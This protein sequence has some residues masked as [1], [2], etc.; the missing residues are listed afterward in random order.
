MKRDNNIL[1][2]VINY[3]YC[4]GCGVCTQIKGS[5]YVIQ[6]N[7]YGQYCAIKNNNIE[8]EEI[9]LDILCVC[10]F[11]GVSLNED[12]ISNLKF[13]TI[14]NHDFH[15]G[16]YINTYAGY[17]IEHNVRDIGA[18]G[19]LTT[20]LLIYLF[21]NKLIDGVIHVRST[22]EEGKLFK[23][24]ISTS[25]EQIKEGAKS[26]YYPIELSEVLHDI[27]NIEG[28]YAIVGVPCFIKAVRL[29]SIQDEAID[30]KIKYYI[31]LV[32]GHLKSDFFAKMFAW[33]ND[34]SPNSL[35]KI[36]FRTK[37]EGLSSNN[38]GV[39]V[40]SEQTEKIS[41]P[42][43]ELYGSNWGYG[44]FKYKACDYCDD[45]LAETADIVFG[46]AWLSRYH[47]DSKGNNIVIVRN[48]ELNDI[49]V[50]SSKK[51]HIN[52]DLLSVDEIID[53]QRGGFSHRRDGLS[54]RLY[55]DMIK[56]RWTPKKRVL[57][58]CI[59]DYDMLEKHLIRPILR[60]ESLKIFKEA[61]RRDDFNYF[62]ENIKIYTDKYDILYKRSLAYRIINRMKQELKKRIKK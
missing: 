57:P 7:E 58:K 17:A 34:I 27:R 29:L 60:D 25:I 37:L 32:C 40:S 42:I 59:D 47:K 21:E 44:F 43:S 18:S 9:D 30:R 50:N 8:S 26:K 52:L 5:P 22:N 3:N 48:N 62:L 41:P 53:S 51:G 16:R 28:N 55:N 23:Y 13:K 10:P 54:I 49:L 20:W 46:D 1:R 2:K 14:K 15:L 11:S 61:I 12:E 45:V 19:G 56:N 33:H 36:D 6:K 4:I 35:I 24:Q 38:Y 39:T 31:G